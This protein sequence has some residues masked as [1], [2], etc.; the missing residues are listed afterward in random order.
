MTGT[1]CDALRVDAMC[2]RAAHRPVL[3]ARPLDQHPKADDGVGLVSSYHRTHARDKLR[4]AWHLN[5]R[6]PHTR[7]LKCGDA[8]LSEGADV[9]LVP[10]RGN[11][12]HGELPSS[13]LRL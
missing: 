2:N 6:H 9:V 7:L 3:I 4:G 12:A 11:D 8:A 10:H 5:A 1:S 13:D